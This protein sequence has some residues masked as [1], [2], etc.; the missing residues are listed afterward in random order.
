MASTL[1]R[2]LIDP[3]REKVMA[4]ERLDFDDG[5]ALLESDDLLGLGELADAARRLRGGTD[6]VYFVNNLYL[7]HTNVCRVKCKFCA[8]A[9]THKQDGAY[10]WEIGPLTQHALKHYEQEPFSE[11][12]MVGGESPYLDLDYYLDL[13]RSLKVALP[14]VTLMIVGEGAERASLTALAASLGIADR[15][16]IAG[17]VPH[18]ALPAVIAA[19]DVMAL[20]SRS[21]G[22]ANAWIEALA[23]GTPVVIP[24][25]GGA[26]EVVTS[27]DAGRI[28]ARTPEAFA[29]AI[30]ELIAAPP[31]PDAVSATV[32][33]FTWQA[34][35]AALVDH[36]SALVAHRRER[37]QASSG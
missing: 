11:I 18:Q 30:Q 36:L 17:G 29:A 31:A 32:R 23:C 10:T 5:V 28:V 35:T 2:T 27:A 16:R 19:A 8:F 22:L 24:P 33:R 3:V 7:N 4:G 37:D 21:E 20:A 13:V 1:T 34:N 25:I 12:H 14:G 6:E 26:A 15:V 9:R